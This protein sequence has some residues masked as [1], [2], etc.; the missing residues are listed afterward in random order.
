M[1][2]NVIQNSKQILTN[3]NAPERLIEAEPSLKDKILSF[4]KGASGD[5]AG[6]PKLSATAKKYYRTYKNLFDEFS[7]RNAQNNAIEPLINKNGSYANENGVSDNLRTIN[8]NNMSVSG[9]VYAV[10]S[11]SN[12]KKY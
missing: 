8:D 12:G 6:T 3:R 4:F 10:E 11:D 5:Y 7:V 2:Y 1:K 9:R